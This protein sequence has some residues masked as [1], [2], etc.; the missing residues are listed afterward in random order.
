MGFFFSLTKCAATL[1]IL[2]VALAILGILFGVL[3]STGDKSAK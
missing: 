1:G 3:F 2:H